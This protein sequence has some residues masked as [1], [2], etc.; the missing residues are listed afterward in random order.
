MTTMPTCRECNGEF[1]P[2][3]MMRSGICHGCHD[4][5]QRL[6]GGTTEPRQKRQP[7]ILV[8]TPTIPGRDID[9]A[10]GIVSAQVAFGMNVFKD[11]ATAW[12]D[13][14]G[15]RANSLQGVLADSR[16]HVL[17]EL[18]A[19][20]KSLGADAVVGI[21]LDMSEFSVGN[22]MVMLIATGTAVKLVPPKEQLA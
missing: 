18:T 17:A 21:D 10:I 15:G 8:T 12:R 9:E 19:E 22:G 6:H 20:A 7:L 11:I 14:F 2:Y 3:E 16:K 13:V 5:I 1:P 4:A